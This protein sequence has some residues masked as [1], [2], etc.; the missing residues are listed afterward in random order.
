MNTALFDGLE[1][2][3]SDALHCSWRG[4]LF[5]TPNDQLAQDIAWE[6]AHFRAVGREAYIKKQA[7]ARAWL[8]T[9]V[10]KDEVLEEEAWLPSALLEAAQ[11]GL[12]REIADLVDGEPP[13]NPSQFRVVQAYADVHFCEKRPPLIGELLKELGIE[14]PRRTRDNTEVW[15]KL[16]NRERGIERILASFDLPL[17]PGKRGPLSLN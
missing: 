2:R 14:K 17:S 8:K 16:D 5:A 4:R 13:I 11:H 3:I 12:L 1:Q 6:I 10:F 15:L 9:S 7:E